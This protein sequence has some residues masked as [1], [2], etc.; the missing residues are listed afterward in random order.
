MFAKL[1]VQQLNYMFLI[2]EVALM[3]S[4]QVAWS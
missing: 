4:Q 1:E 3:I 2:N